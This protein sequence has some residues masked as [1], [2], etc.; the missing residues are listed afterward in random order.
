[1]SKAP[2][3]LVRRLYDWSGAPCARLGADP[4]MW[5][6]EGRTS[7]ALT[8]QKICRTQCPVLDVCLERALIEEGD[9][10]PNRRSGTRG[11]LGPTARH[12]LARQRRQEAAAVVEAS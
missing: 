12:R 9:S 3:I 5:D 8:A 10:E 2:D 6:A 1:M 4:A 11:G 7:A